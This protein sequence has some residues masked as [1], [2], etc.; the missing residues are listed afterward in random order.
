MEVKFCQF[1]LTCDLAQLSQ[2]LIFT[3]NKRFIK[4][5]WF[6]SGTPET[7]YF[8]EMATSILNFLG[9][10][11]SRIQP[12]WTAEIYTE[13]RQQIDNILRNTFLGS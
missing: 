7:D 10:H 3:F 6:S 2:I 5:H 11:S 1:Y 13:D 12:D 8:A 9:L 4:I